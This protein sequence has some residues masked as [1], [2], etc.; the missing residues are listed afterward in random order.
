VTPVLPATTGNGL[1]MRAGAVLEALARH[2]RVSLHVVPLYRSHEE[3]APELER[4]CVALDEGTHAPFPGRRFDVVH[5]FRL[6]TLPFARSAAADAWHV[7][8]DDREVETRR[9]IAALAR[10][11][12]DDGLAAM[13]EAEADAYEP[14]EEE[15]FASFDRVYLAAPDPRCALLPNTVRLPPSAPEG[16][17]ATL[18]FVG[19][20]G[21][22]PNEDAVRWL[23]A[24]ILPELRRL[25]RFRVV[26][27]GGD[28]AVDEPEVEVAGRVDDVAPFYARAGVAIAPLRAGGGTRIKLLEAFAHGVPAVSTTAGN[29]GLGSRDGEHLLI[30]DTPADFARACARLTGDAGLRACLSAQAR[31]Y[32]AR[33]HSPDAA[34]RAVAPAPPR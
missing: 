11:N 27:V 7:D 1:A 32:V 28:A 15:A 20:L 23:C 24:E 13:L 31:E 5:V 19:N 14:L 33:A 3:L 2:Y 9:R 6:A 34:A 26:V 17:P 30:A 16:D 22:Y 18:L 29:E 21:H 4:C 12:G 10:S 25:G 8:F